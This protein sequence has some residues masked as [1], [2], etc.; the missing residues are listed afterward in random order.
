MQDKISY[1]QQFRDALTKI[2]NNYKRKNPNLERLDTYHF[3]RSTDVMY[4]VNN[5]RITPMLVWSKVDAIESKLPRPFYYFFMNELGDSIRVVLKQYPEH[6]LNLYFMQEQFE[7]SQQAEATHSVEVV[8]LRTLTRT[9]QQQLTGLTENFHRLNKE[10][11]DLK[12]I[13]QRLNDENLKLK[14]QLEKIL[15][16]TDNHQQIAVTIRSNLTAEIQQLHDSEREHK[17]KLAIIV[18]EK[19]D[20]FETCHQLT[21]ENTELRE[22]NKK[23][24]EINTRLAKEKLD[25]EQLQAKYLSAV[26]ETEMRATSN[27]KF[28]LK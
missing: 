20:L 17:E 4:Y 7:L 14:E 10:N 18:N 6:T 23:L 13:N 9:L 5:L 26:Q 8:Q 1:Q 3:D 27:F 22:N 11:K 16:T 19:S 25:L 15:A 12:Y 21:A 24:V 28:F 2:I